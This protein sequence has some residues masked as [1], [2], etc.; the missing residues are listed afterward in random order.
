M[1]L[2]FT[3]N[4][5]LQRISNRK[6]ISLIKRGNLWY[7]IEGN[8][9]RSLSAIINWC[10]LFSGTSDLF[11]VLFLL[12]YGIAYIMRNRMKR[13][14]VNDIYIS[15]HYIDFLCQFHILTCIKLFYYCHIWP[16]M[17]DWTQ[18]LTFHSEFTVPWGLLT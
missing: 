3:W 6:Q 12:A 4:Y 13:N 11:W 10:I 15:V 16:L 2:F 14:W 1:I 9:I 5:T 7:I 18:W 17:D 8:K